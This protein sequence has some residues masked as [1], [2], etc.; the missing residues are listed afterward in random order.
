VKV[1]IV[2]PFHREAAEWLRVC[3]QSVL[4]QVHPAELIAVGDGAK[5]NVLAPFYKLIELPQA[6]GDF[7]NAARAIGAME[8]IASGFDAVAFL[9]ADNWFSPLHVQEM[10]RL[11]CETGAVVCTA[12]QSIA[13]VDGTPFNLKSESDGDKHA[14]TSTIFVT[15]EAFPLL[16]NWALIPPELAAVGDRVWWLLAKASGYKRAHSELE[17]VFYRNR[18]AAQY[19]ALGEVPPAGTKEFPVMKAGKFSIRVPAMSLDFEIAEKSK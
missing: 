14:D 13:R 15:R 19:R 3:F 9:D 17:T 10:L 4:D 18:H 8:A 2:V 16:A 7:G 11:H 5:P 6:H 1:A 12:G